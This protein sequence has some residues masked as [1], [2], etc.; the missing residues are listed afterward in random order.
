MSGP[1][2]PQA[3]V[4]LR[5]LWEDFGQ[6]NDPKLQEVYA[7]PILARKVSVNINDYSQADTF[8]CEI[9]YKQFPFDPRS[10][11]ACGVTISMQDMKKLFSD[12]KSLEQIKPE[13]SNTVFL[14]FADEEAISFDDNSRTVRLEGRDLTALLLDRPWLGGTIDL[15]RPLDVIIQQLL[16]GLKE[17]EKL[18]VEKRGISSTLPTLGQ[19]A[20]SFTSQGQQ[21]SIA[22]KES[23]WDVIQDLTSRAGLIAYVEVDRLVI[24]KPRALYDAKKSVQFVYGRNLNSLEFKRKLGRKKNFNIA[25]NSLNVEAKEIVEAKIPEE[26]T[27]EWCKAMGIKR[28]RIKIPRLGSDQNRTQSGSG[29]ANQQDQD[30]PFIGF[31]IP[32]INNKQRLVEIGQE[33]FEE[34][35]RQQIEGSFSTKDMESVDG[36]N[37]CFNL[38]TLRNGTPLRI[39]IDQGD[40]KGLKQLTS[41]EEKAAFLKRRGYL[42]KVAQVLADTLSN[43]RFKSPFYTKSVEF[44][45]DSQNGFEVRVEFINFIELPKNLGGQ[46]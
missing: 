42:P 3:A 28:E 34:I 20:N 26:A 27:D 37:T 29:T 4:T 10:I 36:T 32:N 45:L 30:A 43:P 6:N 33:L 14:G 9:D 19:Y 13:R 21:K 12:G 18:I 7:L 8:S 44:T 22:H 24:T 11:R 39:E 15:A 46:A 16:S 41:V 2:Y 23:Y 35:G 5:I 17:T 1:Y 38:L 40:L 25:V 31:R